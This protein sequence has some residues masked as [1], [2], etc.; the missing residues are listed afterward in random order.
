MNFIYTIFFIS[1]F[2]VQA[3]AVEY[4]S[5][6]ELRLESR[7][8]KDDESANTTDYGHS[9]FYR[10]EGDLKFEKAQVML[11]TSLVGRAA[12]KDSD[13]NRFHFEDAYAEKDFGS[14]QVFGGFRVV[15]WSTAEAFHPSDIINSRDFDSQFENA[16]KIGELMAGFSSQIGELG[17]QAFYMPLLRG[18]KYPSSNNR[19]SFLPA[20]LSVVSEAF[21]DKSGET[22]DNTGMQWAVKTS[23]SKWGGDWSLYWVHQFDR[24]QPTFVSVSFTELKPVFVEMDQLGLNLQQQV[25]DFMVKL[26]LAHRI[27]DE[28]INSQDFGILQHKSHTLMAGGLEYIYG[29]DKGSETTLL[30]EAQF[31]EGLGRAD[32]RGINLFQRDALIGFRHAFNNAAG[33]ELVLIGIADLEVSKQLMLTLSYSQRLKHGFKIKIGGRY[34]DAPT[35]QIINTDLRTFNKDHQ[36]YFELSK[37]F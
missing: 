9:L 17:V 7:I 22:H 8:F 19:L 15:N 14:V 36:A 23:Y 33:S 10:F 11:K 4:N 21:V 29:W 12:F 5:R 28:N 31:A 24:S 2:S 13:R 16:G 30:V 3:F 1:I 25:G 37:F 6:S 35:D 26:E 34:V 27:F 20:G 18:P 32:R